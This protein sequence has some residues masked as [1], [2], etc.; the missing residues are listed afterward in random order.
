MDRTVRLNDNWYI[1]DGSKKASFLK[2][3]FAKGE[4][5]PQERKGEYTIARKFICPKQVNDTVTVF[6][7]GDFRE[8]EVFADKTKLEAVKTDEGKNVYDVTP[9]LT[10]GSTVIS[11]T[12]KGGK[13][14]AFYFSVK[15]KV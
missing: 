15:R 4:N 11:A 5:L 13:T 14:T 1:T 9:F 12:V 3:R 2:R 7:E 6:F 10:H 8:I